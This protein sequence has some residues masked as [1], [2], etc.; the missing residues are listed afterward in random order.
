M[1]WRSNS[2]SS[3]SLLHFRE[4]PFSWSVRGVEDAVL[5]LEPG[6]W[7][8]VKPVEGGTE[9]RQGAEAKE[10]LQRVGATRRHQQ[11]GPEP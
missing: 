7:V 2:E 3:P 9:R 8:I 6:V 5:G 11:I 1:R 10:L 4:V